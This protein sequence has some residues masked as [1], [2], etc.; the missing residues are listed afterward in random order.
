MN[1]FIEKHDMSIIIDA[2]EFMQETM[3]QRELF[4]LPSIWP[5]S[6]EDIDILSQSFDT[7]LVENTK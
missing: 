3:R 6:K 4:G 1:F 2:L 5:Y 7:S